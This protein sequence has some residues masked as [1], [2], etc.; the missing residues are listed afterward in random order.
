MSDT[1]QSPPAPDEDRAP[2][3]KTVNI[4]G[5]IGATGQVSPPAPYGQAV[6][7]QPPAGFPTSP[8]DGPALDMYGNPVQY[9]SEDP[10]LRTGDPNEIP[11]PDG[12]NP[13]APGPRSDQ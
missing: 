2:V 6:P 7:G 1:P 9:A 11:P 13:G 8:P 12:P 10:N 4:G 5:E 3:T